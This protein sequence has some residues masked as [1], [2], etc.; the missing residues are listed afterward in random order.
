[1]SHPDLAA[2]R[3]KFG[4]AVVRSTVSCG[5]DIVWLARD[6]AHAIL[7]WL[8]TDQGYD[9]LVDVTAVEY[10]DPELPLEVV[11]FVRNLKTD[12]KSV[13]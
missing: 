9:Y 13:V 7:A 3:A 2:L 12:R 8:K 5:D 10:R 6:Q 11:W 1:M 4:A